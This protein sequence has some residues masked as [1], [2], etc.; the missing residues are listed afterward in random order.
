MRLR[1]A[2]QTLGFT[3]GTWCRMGRELCQLLTCRHVDQGLECRYM[4]R[5]GP[6]L[7]AKG[8][9]LPEVRDGLVE[10]LLSNFNNRQEIESQVLVRILGNDAPGEAL[11]PVVC[12][13]VEGRRR[14]G[15]PLLDG[16]WLCRPAAHLPSAEVEIDPRPVQERPLL[17]M[18]FDELLEGLRC[19]AV[20]V[21]LQRLH[22]LLK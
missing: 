18:P 21:L 1:L 8:N 9:R 16:S 14:R 4:A 13:I 2:R 6:C 15:Q 5:L 17:G 12:P 11:G 7:R 10:G 20:L 19:R 22:A 3:A